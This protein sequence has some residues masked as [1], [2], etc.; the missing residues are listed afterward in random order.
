[1]TTTPRTAMLVG[2][3]ALLLLPAAAPA[4]D[5][6]WED[7]A[8][9]E[10]GQ[11]KGHATLMPFASVKEAL[12]NDRKA[13][14][15]CLLLSGTWKFDWAPVPAKA[16]ER[17]FEEGFDVSGWADIQVPG[18]WQMQGFGHAKFRNIQHPF[19]SDPPR[20]PKDD[21][22]VGSYRRTFVLPEAWRDRQVFLHFEAV[23]SASTV[24]VNGREVGYNE[25]GLEPAEYDVTAHVRPGEN[26]L[27]VRVLRWSDGTY[28]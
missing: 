3:L 23:Q 1:M 16:P 11:V 28:L 20:V 17:F 4:A 6:P 8:V 18:S 2:A 12:A 25:G 21:N 15:S 26:T 14:A 13:S 9:F 10:R 27:A 24:W 5:V 7:P 22:P 19:P